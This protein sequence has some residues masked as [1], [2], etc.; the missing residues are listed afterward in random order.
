MEAG[1]G[2]MRG[3]GEARASPAVAPP[4]TQAWNPGR[5]PRP[6]TFSVS[7]Q[8][9]KDQRLSADGRLANSGVSLL[10]KTELSGRMKQGPP[11]V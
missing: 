5:K 10:A 9:W 4:W 3:G 8:R 1:Q 11:H 2:P 7:H 6:P